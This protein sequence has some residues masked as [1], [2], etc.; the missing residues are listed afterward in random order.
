MRTNHFRLIVVVGFCL[1][2]A[3][4]EKSDMASA[5]KPERF[6]RVQV[7]I[8]G[9]ADTVLTSPAG[10]VS[11]PDD[12]LADAGDPQDSKTTVVVEKD[13]SILQETAGDTVWLWDASGALFNKQGEGWSRQS[14]TE[15]RCM[16]DFDFLASLSDNDFEKG[17]RL[18]SSS[19]DAFLQAFGHDPSAVEQ[20]AAVFSIDG[21]K[22]AKI[23]YSYLRE[24]DVYVQVTLSFAYDDR[25]IPL[26]ATANN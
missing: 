19:T 2:L 15:R 1:I 25:S 20:P 6:N 3:G 4:C 7:T 14:D 13:G 10:D 11:T 24:S 12:P 5:L 22:L 21:G 26:P 17:F 9:Q 23:E 18:K 16:V 8:E